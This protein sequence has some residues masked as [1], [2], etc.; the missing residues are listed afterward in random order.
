M[1]IAMLHWAFPPVV[2]GVETH[3]EE[4]GASL[5]RRGHA[6]S[7]LVGAQS[8]GGEARRHRGIEV[9]PAEEL[10]LGEQPD[11]G[12][13]RR[14]LAS[15]VDGAR[16]DIVHAHNMH[17]FSEPHIEA[18]KDLKERLGVPLVLTAHNVWQDEMARRFVRYAGIWDR[19]IAVSHYLARALAA[20]GYPPERI[21]VVHHG[22]DPQRW[23]GQ[24]PGP[25]VPLRIFHPARL[26]LDKG[27]L[28]VVRAFSRIVDR[29]PA[30]R[31]LLAGTG[32]IVDFGSRQAQ[33]VAAVRAEIERLGIS[34]R[35][36][37]RAIPWSEIPQAYADSRVVVYP[38]RFD[39]PF[40]IAALEGMASTRPVVVT[41]VGGMPEFV[42]DGRDGFII[43]PDDENVLSDRIA[44]LLEN[45]PVARR[46]GI[47]ARQHAGGRFHLRQMVEAM[48]SVY[49]A[50]INARPVP[51]RV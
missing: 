51:V 7:A 10:Q 39:E 6:V 38:S 1:R 46:I 43:P 44:F 37:L 40:G 30:A 8:G 25:D 14:V 19:I 33:E 13:I 36:E 2:G 20:Q 4:L 15:F 5:V 28:L 45:P 24:P 29:M 47:A 26:S 22:I 3:L 21:T 34:E 18:L 41:R 12:R 49:Q 32:K 42:R 17:Y 11:P 23:A 48:L 31:L 9:Q 27:S 50:T 35:V 16:P